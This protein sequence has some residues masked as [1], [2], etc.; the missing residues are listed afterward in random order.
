M[1]SSILFFFFVAEK[2]KNYF[3]LKTITIL[4]CSRILWSSIWK[5]LSE[6]GVK[7]KIAPDN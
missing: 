6:N 1:T 4:L 5:E 7:D 2:K 3:K